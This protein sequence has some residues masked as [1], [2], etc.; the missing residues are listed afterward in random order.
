MWRVELQDALRMTVIATG[1]SPEDAADALH[2]AITNSLPR[3]LRLWCNGRLMSLRE[4]A[5]LWFGF[6]TARKTNRFEATPAGGT[7]GWQGTWSDYRFEVDG[8]ELQMLLKALNAPPHKE[9]IKRAIE[10][11]ALDLRRANQEVNAGILHRWASQRYE[12]FPAAVPT[13]RAIQTW[14]Y[15]EWGFPKPPPKKRQRKTGGDKP[16]SAQAKDT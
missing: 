10:E 15:E 1:W 8:A 14:L 16:K 4:V 13:P 5:A 7:I 3:R 12:K 2:A 11:K 9:D 6:D